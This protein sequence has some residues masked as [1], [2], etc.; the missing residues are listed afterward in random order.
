MPAQ[1]L[2]DLELVVVDD[3]ST[4]SSRRIVERLRDGDA[5][6]RLIVHEL[7][8]GRAQA[9]NSAWQAARA[10]YV[11]RLDADD[12]A[13][14]DRLALQVAYLDEH[15]AVA[16]VG[17]AA[18]TIDGNGRRG[19]LHALP[20]RERRDRRHS[21]QAQLPGSFDREP[22]RRTALEGVGGYRIE[23]LED[24]DL[25]LRLAEQHDLANLTE[26]LVLYRLHAAQVLGGHRRV[27]ERPGS[28]CATQHGAG[29]K[30]VSTRWQGSASSHR[31]RC[32][33]RG[34][35]EREVARGTE[36]EALAW[37]AMLAELGHEA[38][39]GELIAEAS[40]TLGGGTARAFAA[41]KALRRAN[42]ELHARRPFSAGLRVLSASRT[43]RG[44]PRG[45]DRL[46]GGSREQPR[47]VPVTAA[48]RIR[49][50]ARGLREGWARLRISLRRGGR[51]GEAPS[52]LP[53]EGEPAEHLAVNCIVFS[54]N[55]P[56][57]LDALLR[58]LGSR[59]P[60]GG[61]ITVIYRASGAEYKRGYEPLSEP[62]GRGC[63]RRGTTSAGPS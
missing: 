57:Q 55:R 39:A 14:P 42:A 5:R 51:R 21:S 49:T 10:P 43:R 48:V 22:I 61:S 12:L 16:A 29:G 4:D 25:W 9:A 31:R 62:S 41:E 60:Y 44:S 53:L 17:G 6:V 1:T 7:N 32:A 63:W 13:L 28:P 18:V 56:M 47:A 38:E 52:P 59:A 11:A 27:R 40:R 36:H 30:R 19:S 34:L 26:P 3:G 24:Y 15:P 33:D 23:P 58:T 46:V 35:D 50:R 8:L 45:D 37:A 2:D 20:D 54:K